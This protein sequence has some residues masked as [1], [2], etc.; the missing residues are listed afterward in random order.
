[1]GYS[2]EDAARFDRE[3][4]DALRTG[5]PKRLYLKQTKAGNYV[6]Y[7]RVRYKPTGKL[8]PRYQAMFKTLADLLTF[9]RIDYDADSLQQPKHGGTPIVLAE[10][11]WLVS[12]TSSHAQAHI[13]SLK[14]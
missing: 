7:N 10:D 3:I 6:L 5:F 14:E 2:V 13:D 9:L 12:K 1:M 4:E 11:S 8:V